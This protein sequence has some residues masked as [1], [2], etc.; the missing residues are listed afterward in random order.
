M[1]L[2]SYC[3]S[4]LSFSAVL[5]RQGAEDAKSGASQ[6]RGPAGTLGPAVCS[7][8]SS[9]SGSRG[10]SLGWGF[11]LKGEE[12]VLSLCTLPETERL[13][14]ELAMSPGHCYGWSRLLRVPSKA[15]LSPRRMQLEGRT[16]KQGNL[17]LSAWEGTQPGSSSA[18]G[19]SGFSWK[20]SAEL[21]AS[22]CDE[23]RKCHSWMSRS[24]CEE[25]KPY[26]F[27]F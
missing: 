12:F 13:E 18:L 21:T 20:S 23:E 8:G 10:H 2:C 22:L 24:V 16:L 6:R 19:L 5:G 15:R 3:V 26:F 25:C 7:P 14:S 4:Y 11:V 9:S 17:G 1:S 27:F